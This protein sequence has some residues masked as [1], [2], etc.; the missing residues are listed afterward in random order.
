LKNAGT[1]AQVVAVFF[2]SPDPATRRIAPR[3]K[4]KFQPIT[5]SPLSS[6]DKFAN[7]TL[8]PRR[9]KGVPTIVEYAPEKPPF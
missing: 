7:A 6:R 3:Q 9:R 2:V 5:K 1:A 4:I 8:W